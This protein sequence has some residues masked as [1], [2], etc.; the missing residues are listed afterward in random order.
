MGVARYKARKGTFWMV[1][2]WMTGADGQL[3]RFRK[4]RIPTK[5]MALALLAKARADA[6]EGRYF[7]R[8]QPNTLTVEGTWK[9]YEPVSRRDNDT[10]Q[11][12]LARAR[13]LVRHLGGK[14][15]GRL[16]EGDV[17]AYRTARLGETTQRGTAPSPATLDREVELL[18]RILNYAVR[19]GR[20]PHNPVAKAKLLRQPNVREMVLDDE[21]FGK[22]VETAEPHL[23]PILLVAYD[24]GMRKREILDLRWS[25]VDLRDGCIRLAAQDTKTEKPR[26]VYLTVRVLEALRSLPRNIHGHVFV[27]PETGQPW[28]D[29]RKAFGRARR[30]AGLAGVWFHDLRRSFVTNARKAGVPESVVMRMSGHKTRAVFDRY[31]IV[32]DDDVREAVRRIETGRILGQETGQGLV[33]ASPETTKAL[34]N[35]KGL[36]GLR[37]SGG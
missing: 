31:N 2:E 19:C 36:Q 30:G 34:G 1:D 8:T 35:P 28:E 15:A 14:Q 7:E 26:T 23:R 10:W 33:E 11:T 18:K 22:L 32:S 4:R 6:F 17:D 13:H 24:S 21:A 29:L 5:E 37:S 12:E 25:Q 9:A 3:V 27:N 16:T 20:L